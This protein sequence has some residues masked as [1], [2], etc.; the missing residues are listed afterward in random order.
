MDSFGNNFY[1]RGTRIWRYIKYT[2]LKKKKVKTYTNFNVF[3]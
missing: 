3:E 2:F 1:S